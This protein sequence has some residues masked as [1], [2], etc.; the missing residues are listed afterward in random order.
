MKTEL[1]DE[2]IQELRVKVAE[3]CGWKKWDGS[4]PLKYRRGPEFCLADNLPDYPND[5]N[6]MHEA[7]KLL[8]V[9]IDHGNSPR[10]TYTRHLYNL[11]CEEDGRSQPCRA[12]ATQRALAFVMT[13]ERKA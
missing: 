6:A 10:Y 1:T 11:V 12:T 9:D 2:Q 8:D 5:L 13:M 7:E 3:L 4:K